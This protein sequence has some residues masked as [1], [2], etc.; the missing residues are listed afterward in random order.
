MA[1]AVEIDQK[2]TIADFDAF[3]AGLS[4][5]LEYELVDGEIVMMSNP[6]ETHEQIASN[7]GARLKLAMDARGCWTYQGGMRVQADDNL[8]AHDKFRPDVVVR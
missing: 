3:V 6:T 4:T 1:Q 5:L 7:I 8:K 2:A